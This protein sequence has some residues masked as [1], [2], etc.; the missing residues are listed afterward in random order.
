MTS[1]FWT[2]TAFPVLRGSSTILI[3]FLILLSDARYSPADRLKV[4][5][6]VERL[7]VDP[8]DIPFTAERP[9]M[10]SGSQARPVARP[11]AAPFGSQKPSIAAPT[12]TTSKK[13]KAATTKATAAPTPPAYPPPASQYSQ[14]VSYTSSQPTYSQAPQRAGQVAYGTQ[15]TMTQQQRD[16]VAYADDDNYDEEE[17]QYTDFY[18]S[19]Q[20]TVVGIQYYDGLGE[21]S[22]QLIE[23]R[24]L[25][26]L[27]LDLENK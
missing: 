2:S 15:I 19:F 20:S 4:H 1:R 16:D 9:S 22:L 21:Q 27:Q 25:F 12:A 11:S 26:I 8:A 14:P 3:R 18:L 7:T 10:P 13:R 5:T 24:C 17:A 6:A 23:T